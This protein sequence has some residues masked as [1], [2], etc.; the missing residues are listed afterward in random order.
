VLANEASGRRDGPHPPVQLVTI[1]ATLERGWSSPPCPPRARSTGIW[2]SLTV[3]TG[4]SEERL[5]SAIRVASRV[6]GQRDAPS[7]LWTRCLIAAP[8]LAS[9]GLTV[10]YP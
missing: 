1:A 8:T 10:D 7:K 5:T 6:D 9:R 3:N 2:R 4:R